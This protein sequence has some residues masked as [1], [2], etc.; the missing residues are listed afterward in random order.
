MAAITDARQLGVEIRSERIVA[1]IT[2]VTWT[3]V[4]VWT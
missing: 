3:V 4:L 2:Q 1:R